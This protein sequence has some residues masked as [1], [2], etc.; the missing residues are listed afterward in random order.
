MHKGM[1]M[2]IDTNG[3]PVT[4]ADYDESYVFHRDLL[5]PLGPMED[6]VAI[7]L[8]DL[9][10]GHDYSQARIAGSID[11]RS[12]YWGKPPWLG[13]DRSKAQRG[14]TQYTATPWNRMVDGVFIPRSNAREMQIDSDGHVVYL[15]PNN[16]T[17]WGPIWARRRSRIDRD[18]DFTSINRQDQ[19]G[20]GTLE[21]VHDRLRNAQEGLLGLH[22]NVGI[23][24]DLNSVRDSGRTEV[25]EFSALLVNLG[26]SVEQ[27]STGKP[28]LADLRVFVDGKLR[29]SRLEF[30]AD[31]G[32]EDVV[33]ALAP[34]DRFLTLVATDSDGDPKLDHVVFVDP[35][36]H[37]QKGAPTA[38]RATHQILYA[39]K[40]GM[41]LA[42]P[43][44]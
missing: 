34:G 4:L 7:S 24:F 11:P 36:L 33:V 3:A 5:L 2:R 13:S 27:G 17:S 18:Q 12:G 8:I 41:D 14:D 29:Y 10:A 22:S 19:W 42:L 23:T 32:E 43:S 20:G 39:A 1:S 38:H 15:P 25:V 9:I 44:M 31:D 16:G 30:S 21:A 28:S 26:A 6:D 37:I 35:V 40:Q